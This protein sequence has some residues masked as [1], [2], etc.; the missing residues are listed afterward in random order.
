MAS[1]TTL[2]GPPLHSMLI[3]FSPGLLTLA[4]IFDIVSLITGMR[5]QAL[6]AWA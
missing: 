3:V 4:L 1:R 2:F 6:P 5:K